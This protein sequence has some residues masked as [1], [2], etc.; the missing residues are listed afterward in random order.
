MED[1]TVLIIEDDEL[2]MKLFMKILVRD[3]YHVI[4]AETAEKGLDLARS[5]KPDLVL[6]D[7]KLPGMDGLQATRLL[8]ASHETAHIPVVAVSAYA[9]TED[10]SRAR[11]AGCDDFVSKPI[12]M[13][14][15][16]TT[17]RRFAR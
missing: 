2:N 11:E 16:L 17:V 13:K 6:M 9:M 8:K 4:G 15:F 14:G 12:D 7:V 5:K 10:I 3:G 1:R